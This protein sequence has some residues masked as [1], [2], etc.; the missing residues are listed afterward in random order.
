M[1]AFWLILFINLLVLVAFLRAGFA[2]REYEPRRIHGWR[3]KINRQLW[4]EEK[5]VTQNAIA[6]LDFKLKNI[7]DTLPKQHHN[8]LKSVVIWLEKDSP[9]FTGMVYHPSAKWLSEHGYNPDK[10]K[11]IEIANIDNFI[12]R[13]ET[14]PWHVLHELAHA[15]HDRILGKDFTAIVDAYDRA[16]S[17]GLYQQVARNRG[18]KLWTAYALNSPSEY[19]AEL[20]EAYFG[21]NDFYPFTK[22]ELKKYDPMGYQAIKKAWK[23]E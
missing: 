16:L 12:G 20:T 21:E 8:F 23:I 11:A 3:V 6:L 2:D 15:Y 1:K 7:E 22:Q 5:A 14:Q 17:T 9:D 13:T 19:F 18:N 4:I 10:A